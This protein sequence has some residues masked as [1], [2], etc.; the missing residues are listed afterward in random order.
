MHGGDWIAAGR[1]LVAEN[2]L[3]LLLLFAAALVAA[4]IING[5][6]PSWWL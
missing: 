4:A 1:Q 3:I 2:G 5:S 6:G